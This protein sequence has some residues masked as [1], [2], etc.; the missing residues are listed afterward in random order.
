MKYQ[1]VC[2]PE[3]SC[4]DR[5]SMALTL[6]GLTAVFS[7]QL[8]RN[9]MALRVMTSTDYQIGRFEVAAMIDCKRLCLRH[10]C[11]LCCSEP[12]AA[13]GI[14][15]GPPKRTQILVD[16]TASSPT[17][18]EMP[19]RRRR[20]SAAAWVVQVP[21]RY[22]NPSSALHPIPAPPNMAPSRFFPFKSFA[23][24]TGIAHKNRCSSPPRPLIMCKFCPNVR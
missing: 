16:T 17:S 3:C 4:V 11:C 10:P 23:E 12:V 18:A 22:T 19:G 24:E 2:S 5:T 9:G 15:I 13:N 20:A 6:G 7:A 8:L 21:S 14:C 1:S